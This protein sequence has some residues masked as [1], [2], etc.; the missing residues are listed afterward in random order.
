MLFME[1]LFTGGHQG[2][3]VRTV[4]NV[5]V[6]GLPLHQQALN[7][8][9]RSVQRCAVTRLYVQLLCWKSVNQRQCI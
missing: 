4:V 2:L 3:L 1:Q 5:K 9:M 7:Y 6:K 8:A